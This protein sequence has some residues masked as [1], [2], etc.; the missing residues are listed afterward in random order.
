M[1]IAMGVTILLAHLSSVLLFQELIDAEKAKIS[2]RLRTAAARIA[3][4]HEQ[5][6][7]EIHPIDSLLQPFLTSPSVSTIWIAEVDSTDAWHIEFHGE[8]HVVFPGVSIIPLNSTTNIS[9]EIPYFNGEFRRDKQLY[10]AASHLVSQENDPIIV[11]AIAPMYMVDRL[12]SV[13]R[14][15][16]LIRVAILVLFIWFSLHFYHLIFVPYQKMRR[17]ARQLSGTVP[18]PVSQSDD[19][20]FVMEAFAEAVTTLTRQKEDL[21]IEFDASKRR[22]ESLEKFNTYIL[23]SMSAGVLILNRQGIILRLNPS[24]AR[25]LSVNSED[26]VDQPH[27]VL[28]E[29]FPQLGDILVAG[30]NNARSYVR[31]EIS[32][33]LDKANGG[34]RHLGVTS[35]LIL[36]EEDQIVGISILL[37]DLTEIKQLQDDLENNRRLAALGEMA[38]GLAHQ[39]RNS[40]T[41]I[42][43]FGRLAERKVTEDATTQTYLA[44]IL[45]EATDTEQMLNQFLSFARPLQP[46]M[47]D[48]SLYEVLHEAVERVQTVAHKQNTSIAVEVPEVTD[49]IVGD[50]LL[51]R[52]VF[53]NLLHNAIES[54]DRGGRVTVRVVPPPSGDDPDRQWLVRVADT[55]TGIAG[56]DHEKIFQP[57]FTSKESGTGLGLPLARKII[58]CHGG[59]LS[60]ESSTPMGTVFLIRLPHNSSRFIERRFSPDETQPIPLP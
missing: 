10:Q 40:M 43:G 38:A 20:E 45:Q 6:I 56:G 39:L 58:T 7:S 55:G 17:Q 2:S 26:I 29:R 16:F 23:N 31:R 53:A 60:V 59:Y 5:G 28:A 50:P 21:E 27:T 9:A 52:E 8:A 15:D 42:V 57:F 24:A 12:R 32:I 33:N 44:D 34:E 48:V 14:W 19:I 18:L 37:T 1:F 36:N 49:T 3:E 46:E 51:L 54:I 30:L 13:Q 41:A 22:Y 35:S 47:R 25:I 4:M 11:G